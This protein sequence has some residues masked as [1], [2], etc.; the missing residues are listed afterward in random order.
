MTATKNQLLTVVLICILCSCSSEQNE[1]SDTERNPNIIYIL[2]D[3]MGYG[4]LS[5]YGQEKF[6]TPNIS[7]GDPVNQGFDEFYG[8]ISQTIAH[9]YYPYT[10]WHNKEE[11]VLAGN[12]GDRQGVYAP[13]LIQDGGDHGSIPC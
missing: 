4:D 2:A 7:E 12:G 5:C 6:N 1:S 9:N 10:L 11:V 3:D 13:N 8:Y